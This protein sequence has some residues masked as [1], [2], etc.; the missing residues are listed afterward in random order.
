MDDEESSAKCKNDSCQVRQVDQR[1]NLDEA[2]RLVANV[3]KRVMTTLTSTY[4]SR[5]KPKET[6]TMNAFDFG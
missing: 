1:V 5:D 6:P 4:E 3:A 2:I